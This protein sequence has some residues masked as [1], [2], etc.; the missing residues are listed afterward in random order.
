MGAF[1]HK[2]REKKKKNLIGIIFHPQPWILN[3]MRT[4]TRIISGS[5]IAAANSIPRTSGVV[6][7]WTDSEA[8]IEKLR[9]LCAETHVL[10]LTM[11]WLKLSCLNRFRLSCGT[12]PKRSSHV[13][14]SP[15][16]HNRLLWRIITFIIFHWAGWWSR[17][18]FTKVVSWQR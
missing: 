2:K 17:L 4:P 12:F 16:T 6:D 18:R 11:A 14:F 9:L 13:Y 5:S 10:R 8:S 3:M 15:S 1:K 7:L